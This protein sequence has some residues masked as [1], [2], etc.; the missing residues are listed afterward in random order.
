MKREG[1]PISSNDSEAENDIVPLEHTAFVSQ[2]KLNEFLSHKCPIDL[3]HI[4][5]GGGG[6]HTYSYGPGLIGVTV[7]V[8][9][10]CGAKT[11]ITDYLSW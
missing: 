1:S 4:E 11:D 2:R 7:I 5:L 6:I 8:S 10:L 3:S 9:C